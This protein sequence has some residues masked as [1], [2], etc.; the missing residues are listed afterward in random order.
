[1]ADDKRDGLLSPYNLRVDVFNL[2]RATLDFR[3]GSVVGI[4][5]GRVE[6]IRSE[7]F[8]WILYKM[9]RREGVFK[10]LFKFVQ[11]DDYDFI[12]VS[13][14][15]TD[16]SLSAENPMEYVVM[17]SRFFLTGQNSFFYSHE[18]RDEKSFIHLKIN[19]RPRRGSGS[20][21]CSFLVYSNKEMVREI[22]ATIPFL[23]AERLSMIKEN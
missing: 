2:F 1:M 3:I 4:T 23:T 13:V 17:V 22:N 20:N 10:D 11:T 14:S 9:G 16:D 18:D 7:V 6:E 19:G 12:T 15:I 5:D 21:F 8:D